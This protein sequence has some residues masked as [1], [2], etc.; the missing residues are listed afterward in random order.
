M[1]R[2]TVY[3][4]VHLRRMR[5]EGLPAWRTRKIIAKAYI[6]ARKNWPRCCFR[7]IQCKRDPLTGQIPDFTLTCAKRK[8]WAMEIGITGNKRVDKLK[9]AG[10]NVVKIGRG[11]GFN[12]DARIAPGNAC[13]PKCSRANNRSANEGITNAR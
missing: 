10:F 2:K 4:M 13:R 3:K 6:K 1:P 5:N 9:K 11:I 12:F 7:L 8:R